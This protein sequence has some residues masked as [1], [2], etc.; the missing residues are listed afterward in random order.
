MPLTISEL[1]RAV[2][3][4]ENYVRQ[5]IFRK[6]LTVQRLDA[7]YPSPTTRHCVGHVSVS[8]PSNRRQKPGCRRRTAPLE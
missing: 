5:H 3:K 7:T 1:A 6:H 4:N 8:S 2:G